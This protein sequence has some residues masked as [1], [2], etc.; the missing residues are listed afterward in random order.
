MSDFKAKIYQIWFRLGLRPEPRGDY[1][2]PKPLDPIAE[3]K[4]TGDIL[5]RAE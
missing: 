5:L 2:A 1:N 3:F 4:V